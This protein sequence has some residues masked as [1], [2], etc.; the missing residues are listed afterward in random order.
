[1]PA[2]P[3]TNAPGMAA[4]YCGDT[5]VKV[6]SPVADTSCSRLKE[7]LKSMSRAGSM[8]CGGGRGNGRWWGPVV[9]TVMSLVGYPVER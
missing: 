9:Y 2:S 3:S 8:V 4:T 6:L 1:M 5:S 7:S